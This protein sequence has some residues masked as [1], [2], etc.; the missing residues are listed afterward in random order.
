[1]FPSLQGIIQRKGEEHART[2]IINGVPDARPMMPAFG[3][4][5]TS[6]DVDNLVA[7]LRTVK[8]QPASAP[9]P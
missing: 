7:F 5:L 9:Q 8:A 2:T 3:D 4:R 6:Q 1:M